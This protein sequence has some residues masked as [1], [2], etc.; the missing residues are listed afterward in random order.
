MVGKI[1]VH[2]HAIPDFFRK[3]LDSVSQ[4]ASGVPKVEWSMDGT[5]EMM[6]KLDIT[7]SILSLSAPGPEIVR[8]M[9]DARALAKP[10]KE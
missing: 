6:A 3:T 5:M 1:D 8:D 4:D 2:T 7:T 9:G 10:F